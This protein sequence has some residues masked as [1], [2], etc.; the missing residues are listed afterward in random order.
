MGKK[1]KKIRKK[2]NVPHN[3]MCPIQNIMCPIFLFIGTRNA[4][5]GQ[6]MFN[7]LFVDLPQILWGANDLHAS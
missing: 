5:L 7:N 2:Y 1:K 3:I 4:D 6:N